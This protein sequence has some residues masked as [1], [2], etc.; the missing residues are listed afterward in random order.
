MD[1]REYLNN[2]GLNWREVRRPSG[3]NAIMN[4]PK[5]DD[6][7]KK[8]AINLETG[9]F[10][11]LHE[12]KCGISG[13]FYDF[14]K[15]FGDIPRPLHNDH[16]SH[17]A[18]Q[19]YDKPTSKPRKL[20]AGTKYLHERGFKDEIIKKFH[21]G[22]TADGK[23]IMYPFYKDGVV[24]NIKYRSITEKKF[25]NEKNGEPVLFNRDN[26]KD[27]DT[28]YIVEGQDDCIALAHY[29]IECVSIPS[30]TGDNRWIEHE[31]NYLQSFKTIIM[32]FDND[33]AGDESVKQIVLRLGK[34][35]C[36]RV[37][38]PEKDANDCL[39]KGIS[40]ETITQCI[41]N[42]VD[43][44]HDHVKNAR[45]Y[46][47]DV[48]DD[49]DNP[50]RQYG[51]KTGIAGLDKIIRGWRMK[52]LSI[53]TG[54]NGSGKTTLLNVIIIE[55]LKQQEKCLSASL[56]MPP[57]TYIRWAIRQF[58]GKEIIDEKDLKHTLDSIGQYWY[59]F[60]I[61]GTVS[62][63]ILIDAFE[64]SA[65]KYGIKHFFI[66]SLMRITF[67]ERDELKAQKEFCEKLFDFHTEYNCHVHLV[68]HPRKGYKDTDQP[69]K[70]DVGGSGHITNSAHNVFSFYRYNEE[71]KEKA[72]AKGFDLP[73]NI[74]S[75]KKNREW[76]TEGDV[77][78]TFMETSKNFL[79]IKNEK[80]VNNPD[81]IHN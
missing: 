30:G 2:K 53:W 56:E 52:E 67:K 22:E 14:Q 21:L 80:H 19:K 81:W 51:I 37:I 9:A 8:F 15:L 77:K 50:I 47:Q 3:I 61:V 39:K 42:P 40:I 41:L 71:Q 36:Y 63:E 59:L 5:C 78:F 12:N 25:W 46:Y 29:G 57:K 60:D 16:V 17:V 24:V 38:L 76:G 31:W 64:F 4:C 74:L 73:D 43:F 20:T 55:L 26:C 32:I 70:V 35:R 48:K 23:A 54:N 10:K 66:D 6:T 1:L 72:T 65:R 27:G 18:Q 49:I 44:K 11:C 33:K 34:W 62:S 68:A 13:S 7:E 58:C 28:L 75:V 69:D 79:E 45:D